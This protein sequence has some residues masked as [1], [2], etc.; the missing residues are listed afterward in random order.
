[1]TK[2]FKTCAIFCFTVVWLILMRVVVGET[3][4]SDNA[5]DWLFSF[6]IQV[7][8]L[9]AVPIVLYKFWVKEDITTGFS[10]KFK[11][12]PVIYLIAIGVGIA[13]HFLIVSISI[14]WQ[15]VAILMG[16]TPTN[17]V[18]TIYSGPEVLILG[19]LT[20]AVLPA[21]F[22]EIT[23]RGLG[24]QMFASTGNEKIKVI[25][26][27]VLFGLGHQFIMQTGYAFV[28]GLVLGFIAVKSRS[29]VPGMIVHFINNFFSVID[30]Y[31]EQNRNAY[32]YFNERINS[33][34]YDSWGAVILTLILSGVVIYGLLLAVKKTRGEDYREQ[35]EEGNYYYPKS[36]QYI[37]EIFGK[38]IRSETKVGSERTA[39]Y[40][41]A[42]L[43][44]AI[45]IMTATTIFSFIWG[46]WR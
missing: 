43:Y 31:S 29:I 8:G 27:A 14:I 10:L 2:T 16:Y 38:L 34:C 23:Y 39:W 28:A 17:S 32:Y 18:G 15:N 21:V 13:L 46:V 20:S 40:E 4:L 25:M 42:F 26:T 1:M 37:D 22:E 36:V 11:I 3:T 5:S 44:A 19:I 12:K 41:Y 33:L 35:N 9:G 6:L 45:A 30:G 7:I 24:M